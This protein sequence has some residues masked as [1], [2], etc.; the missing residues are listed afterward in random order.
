VPLPEVD[1]DLAERLQTGFAV[2]GLPMVFLPISCTT[3]LIALTIAK[4]D[5]VD[6]DVL[7]E[8]AVDL[9]EVDGQVLE[10]SKGRHPRPEVIER[11]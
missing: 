10:V 2:D 5:G 3:S 11:E 6:R 1:A 4:I 7:D 9:D 8:A